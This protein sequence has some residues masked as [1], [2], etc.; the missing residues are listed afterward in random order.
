[1]GA[2]WVYSEDIAITRQLLALGRS[3]AEKARPVIAVAINGS[4]ASG[5]IESGAD[6]V[7]AIQGHNPQPESYADAIADLAAK[8][9]PD[10]IFVGATLQGKDLAAKV[11]ARLKAGL[12]SEAIA[13]RLADGGLETER[14]MYGGMAVATE[15]VTLPAIVTIPPQAYEPLPPEA[16]KSGE[17]I[18]VNAATDDR[19]TVKAVHTFQREGGDITA[20]DVIVCIG[21]GFAKR[22]DIKIAEELAAALNGEVGCTRGVAEDYHW[23]PDSRYIGLSGQ[24]VKPSLYLSLG[25]S[26]QVQHVAGIRDAKL[27][28]AVNTDENA[29][30]FAA[31]DYGIVGDLYEVAPLLAEALQKAAAPGK[32]AG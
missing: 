19:V 20:A 15:T 1:M 10:M 8:E 7:L 12:V 18:A 5:L 27:I 31:A 6:K 14:L 29:P 4:D 26:G 24:K 25:V 32:I 3:L 30:I 13:V 17:V 28:V 11:A 21:R 22:E 2:I 16:G 23:L 9:A